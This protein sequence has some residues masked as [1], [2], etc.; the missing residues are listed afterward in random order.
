MMKMTLRK[1]LF[2]A[3]ALLLLGA[4]TSVDAFAQS[5]GGAGG[6]GSS[7]GV[8]PGGP[9]GAS[10]PGREIIIVPG[11]RRS[12]VDEFPVPTD[13]DRRITDIERTRRDEHERARREERERR[14]EHRRQEDETRRLETKRR[15]AIRR[16]DEEASRFQKLARWLEVSPERLQNFYLEAKAAN[17][18]LRLGQFF[19]AFVIANRLNSSH[20]NV[21]PQAI[22]RGLDSGMS[23][24][25]TLGNLGLTGEEIKATVKWAQRVVNHLK[26]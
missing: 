3:A 19:A 4:G 5:R 10:G 22:L 24:E 2:V 11:G 20:P 15:E 26:P 7:G 14:D 8:R 13:R 21:T 16:Q 6:R 9:G 1:Y 23:L 18:N 12:P 25:R 17:P